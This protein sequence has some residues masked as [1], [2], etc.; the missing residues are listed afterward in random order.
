MQ[1]FFICFF[2]LNG[3]SPKVWPLWFFDLSELNS[4]LLFTF[5]SLYPSVHLDTMSSIPGRNIKSRSISL[6]FKA[7]IIHPSDQTHHCPPQP[8]WVGTHL[9][10][11]QLSHLGPPLP[12]ILIFIIHAPQ[13]HSWV[14]SRILT[15][16]ISEINQ[17]ATL[18][19]REGD[20][21][22]MQ[23]QQDAGHVL[24]LSSSQHKPHFS[25]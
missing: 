20:S 22:W 5:S 17:A 3:I 6:L 13:D 19:E 25:Y 10:R 4:V 15:K 14:M 1:H 23:W 11:V 16:E 21:S 2:L 8:S 18:A 24:F 9:S 12:M 7:N